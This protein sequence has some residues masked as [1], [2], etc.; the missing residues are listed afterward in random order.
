MSNSHIN[1]P[2]AQY[3]AKRALLSIYILNINAINDL[4]WVKQKIENGRSVDLWSSYD[5]LQNLKGYVEVES[6]GSLH[7]QVLEITIL[8]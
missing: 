5:L 8:L 2:E 7:G 1:E 4:K 6:K 3:I